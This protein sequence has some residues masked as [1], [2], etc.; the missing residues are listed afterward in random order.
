MRRLSV[1][2]ILLA[3]TVLLVGCGR[4][5]SDLGEDYFEQGDYKN[6]IVEYNKVLAIKPRNI[7]ILYNR[8]RAYQE[9]SK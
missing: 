7:E 8:G 1:A 9:I 6:A 4:K 5:K 2:V 3:A